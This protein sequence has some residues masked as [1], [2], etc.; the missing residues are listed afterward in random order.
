[1]HQNMEQ[2]L[3]S[4]VAAALEAVKKA[5]VATDEMAAGYEAMKASPYVAVKAKGQRALANS[6]LSQETAKRDL[7]RAQTRHAR[8]VANNAKVAEDGIK[9]ATAIALSQMQLDATERFHSEKMAATTPAQADCSVPSEAWPLWRTLKEHGV[10]DY[11]LDQLRAEEVAFIARLICEKVRDYRHAK[12]DSDWLKIWRAGLVSLPVEGVTDDEAT[13]LQAMAYSYSD[14]EYAAL[15]ALSRIA[16]VA[17]QITPA[18]SLAMINAAQSGCD[19]I[20][21]TAASA[22]ARQL[23]RSIELIADALS[24]PPNSL[25]QARE[26]YESII[27][28]DWGE[29]RRSG[30]K[31]DEDLEEF[32]QISSSQPVDP[33]DDPPPRDIPA[34]EQEHEDQQACIR[35]A[36]LDG[37]PSPQPVAPDSEQLGAIL[38]SDYDGRKIQDESAKPNL[39]ENCVVGDVH[40][41]DQSVP[42]EASAPANG[43]PDRAAFNRLLRSNK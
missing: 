41:Q 15:N 20:R 23:H 29:L 32:R 2:F 39:P 42:T 21:K 27:H 3:K 31:I 9:A 10:K 4:M 36:D 18:L 43:V 11:M 38:T 8:I 5:D 30:Q 16:G 24:L 26:I 12:E 7:K 6:T 19:G 28:P 13:V 37:W 22:V 1:M 35:N 25:D 40:D 14:E 33:D 34:A 17:V